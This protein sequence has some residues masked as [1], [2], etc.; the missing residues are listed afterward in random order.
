M[1][2]KSEE[3]CRKTKEIVIAVAKVAQKNASLIIDEQSKEYWRWRDNILLYE[4]LMLELLTFDVVIQS[5]YNYLFNFLR[6]LE[7]DTNKALRNVS[8]AF[9]N[10]SCLTMMCLTVQ[11]RDI[12][13]A[14]IYFAARFTHEKIPDSEEGKPWWEHLGGRPSKIF[15]AV[16]VM[17]EFYTENPLNRSENPYE[18]SPSSFGNEEELEK[19]RGWRSEGASMSPRDGG[20]YNNRSRSPENSQNHIDKNGQP[21]GSNAAKD[22]ADTPNSIGDENGSSDAKLKAI[23]NDPATHEKNGDGKN[24][25]VDPVSL[26]TVNDPQAAT[27][28]ITPKRKDVDHDEDS[29]AKRQR[30]ENE[31]EASEEGELEE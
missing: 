17:N 27:R 22:N 13:I 10:D 14:A 30:V 1:A 11:P 5:P 16:E 12:A 8:W 21:A 3:N 28:S 15:K 18:Q 24:G 29:E 26:L 7:L 6:E 19:T 4:E 31:S 23:A 20:R 9:L 2:T 25:E